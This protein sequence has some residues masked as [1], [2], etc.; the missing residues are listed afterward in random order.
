[1]DLYLGKEDDMIEKIYSNEKESGSDWNRSNKLFRMPKNIRQI[2]QPED[3]RKIYIED[4]VM[5]YVRQLS[6]KDYNNYQVAVLLGQFI[7]ADGAKSIFIN[8]AVEVKDARL[9]LNYTFSNEIWTDI[10]EDVTEYFKEV[11]I[12]GW[13][14]SKAGIALDKTENIL[15]MHVNNFA[16]Q[17]KTLLMYDCVE[18]EESFYVYYDNHLIKQGGYYIYYEKNEAMQDY[19]VENK[20]SNSIDEGYEDIAMRE[21]RQVLNSKKENNIEKEEKSLVSILYIASTLLAIVI[22]V[23]GATMLNSYEQ[24]KNIEQALGIIKENVVQQEDQETHKEKVIDIETEPQYTEIET[25]SGDIEKIKEG[26]D[27]IGEK[28]VISQN[29][30]EENGEEDKS[31]KEEK[32]AEKQSNTQKAETTK[33]ATKKENVAKE[34]KKE[35]T[36]QVSKPVH[37]IIKE[38]DSL[39]SIS[40]KFYRSTDYVDD[41]LEA[42]GI[43]D[44]DKI[45]IGQK[46]ILP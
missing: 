36:K 28:E 46:I 25:M 27:V 42:N 16:G 41:I 1:M 2:G 7:K 32:E 17:D 34:Q 19:M 14:I 10:Y 11:E 40:K 45:I 13:Y 15:K 18:K 21:I 8:G 3:T 24:M 43:V 31:I 44:Q 29:V 33:K 6:M 20:Q 30:K 12:V 9:A 35:V 5:T 23:I 38:G 39:L 22:L 4:Y 37:Y 26:Y